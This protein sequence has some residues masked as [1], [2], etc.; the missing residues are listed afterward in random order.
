M[1]EQPFSVP[2]YYK[3]FQC[4][5]GDCR[6]SCCGGWPISV[7][8]EEYFRLL[9]MECSPTLRRRLDCAFRLADDPD[10]E[11]YAQICPNYVGDCPMHLENGLCGL[12]CEA[13]ES[14][15]PDVCR[16]FPRAVYAFGGHWCVCSSACEHTVELLMEDDAPLRCEELLLPDSL[17]SHTRP[18]SHTAEREAVR[19]YCLDTITDRSLP[20]SH[21]I[22][23]IATYLQGE[24]GRPSGDS[25][26][27][28]ADTLFA[29]QRTLADHYASHSVSAGEYCRQA[30]AALPDRPSYEA[31][32]DTLTRRFPSLWNWLEKLLTNYMLQEC[33][34]YTDREREV[35][36]EGA[37][38]CGVYA[39]CLYLLAGCEPESREAFVDLM[40]AAFRL[41]GHTAFDHNAIVLIKQ[42]LS[43]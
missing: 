8:M 24:S 23:R 17:L 35:H 20:L 40:S 26:V 32:L 18:V 30:L 27:L 1:S 4:K 34:P 38:L 28:S 3:R 14:I 19:R 21:R 10:G 39:F 22:D 36:Y 6:R 9:G 41:I 37:A 31:A 33:F 5:G 12:Q 29:I 15:L 16:L 2:S 11:H 25:S 42:E 13:G 7:S 43:Q